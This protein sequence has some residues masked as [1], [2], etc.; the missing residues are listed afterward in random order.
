MSTPFLGEVRMFAGNF[1]PKDWALCNGQLL[2]ISQNTALFSLL[3]TY[4][5]GNGTTNFA[6][7]NFQSRVPVGIGQGPGL[8]NRNLGEFFG[9]EA[10]SL[11]PSQIPIHAHRQ[12]ATTNLASS[13]VGPGGAPAKSTSTNFYGNGDASLTFAA[14]A[15][16]ATGGNQPHNNLAPYLTVTFIIA[17]AGIFPSRN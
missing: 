8:S 1:A 10:V 5:G 12:L 15:V 17:T 14:A 11:A 2:A 4:Y 16:G 3:G 13:A 7:P 6:L 9:Q